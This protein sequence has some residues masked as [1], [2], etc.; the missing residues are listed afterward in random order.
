MDNPISPTMIQLDLEAYCNDNCNFCSYRKEDSYNNSMIK[1]LQVDKPHTENKPIGKQTEE[2]HFPKEFARTLPKQLKEAG[3]PAV[4]LTGG[5]EPTIWPHFDELY[6]NLMLED[7]E[8]GLVTNGSNLS[9]NR[10]RM[11]AGYKKTIWVRFSMDASKQEIHKKIHRTPND[12]FDRRIEHLTKLGDWKHPKLTLGISFIITPENYD[13][14]QDSVIKYK[15]IPGVNNIRFSWMYDQTGKAGLAKFEIDGI[16]KHLTELKEKYEDD[17]FQIL[18][19]NNRLDNYSKP[20]TDFDRCYY[21]Q[22]VWNVGADAKVYPCCIMKYHP[23]AV[24][25]D[26]KKQTIKEICNDMTVLAKMKGLKP[27]SCFPCWLRDRS[28]DI[29]VGVERPDHANFV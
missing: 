4:E 19:D 6:H 27:T 8:V 10:I 5:G 16:K 2:G 1:L 22:F 25:A 9:D 11:I 28:K 23:N 13:D 3:V 7:I 12:D 18:F 21:Q 14:I 20:N 15:S 26:L 24:I 17:K 29:A